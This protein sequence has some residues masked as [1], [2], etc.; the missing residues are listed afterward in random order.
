[1]KQLKEKL[2]EWCADNGRLTAREYWDNQWIQ[3]L[4]RPRAVAGVEPF[5]VAAQGRA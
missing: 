2:I 3:Y 4:M 1:M 5:A